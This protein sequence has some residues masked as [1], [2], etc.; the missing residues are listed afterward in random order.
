VSDVNLAATLAVLRAGIDID[1]GLVADA[2]LRI[3]RAGY[4]VGLAGLVADLRTA[5]IDFGRLAA[6]ANDGASS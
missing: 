6:A 4:A 2:T 5:G 1:A 3:A